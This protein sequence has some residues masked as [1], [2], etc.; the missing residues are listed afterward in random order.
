MP[1]PFD[2]LND[3]LSH[4]AEMLLHELLPGGKLVG[5]EYK[6]GSIMG[7]PGDS[8]SFNLD[9]CMGADF[10]TGEKFGDL[11]D[12]ASQVMRIGIGQAAR[13]LAQRI[14]FDIGD[15][16]TNFAPLPP[17]RNTIV[18]DAKP[19]PAIAYDLV[20]P[21]AGIHDPPFGSPSG[22]W[23][24]RDADGKLLFYIARYE[25]DDGGRKIYRPWSWDRIS[26]S[27]MAKMWPSPRPLYGLE[28]LRESTDKPV[29]I[30]EGEKAC[31]AARKI[32]GHIYNCISWPCGANAT[33]KVDWSPVFGKKVLIWP[34]ADDAG[35]QAQSSII[36][37]ISEQAVEI[38]VVSVDDAPEGWDLADGLNT[39][40]WTWNEM[41]EWAKKRIRII[42]A[43]KT[44][45]C[46]PPIVAEV[47][48]ARTGDVSPITIVDN[49]KV[50]ISIQAD[51]NEIAAMIPTDVAATWEELGISLNSRGVPFNNVETAH[52]I[53][54]GHGI[55]QNRLWYDEF[56]S[57]IFTDWTVSGERGR[58]HEITDDDVIQMHHLV[59]RHFQIHNLSIDSVHNAIRVYAAENKR[60]E[61]REW[62]ESLKWDG[63]SRIDLYLKNYLNAQ[64]S[65][66]TR[67]ASGNWWKGIA[68]RI[69][70]P[71][72]QLD[73]MIVL[74]GKQGCGK[75]SSMK[76]V[77]GDWHTEA[78]ASIM[79][80]D[81]FMSLQGK[82]IVEISEMDAFSKAE[83]T[84]VKRV[85]STS[86]DRFRAPYARLPQD[87][88][89]QCVFA[90]TTNVHRF[91]SDETG[92]RRFWP[93]EI[94]Q[95][96]VDA[97]MRDRNQLFAEAVARFKAGEAWHIMPVDETVEMQ[98]RHRH[99]DAWEAPIQ[100]WLAGRVDAEATLVDVARGALQIDT[101]RLD[102]NSQRRIA[103]ILTMN[104]WQQKSVTASDGKRP[105]RVW[106]KP[107][108]EVLATYNSCKTDKPEADQPEQDATL[109]DT[110]DTSH[111]HT[112][113]TWPAEF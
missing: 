51:P 9:K 69:F 103:A 71:G 13:A 104:G 98:E 15:S 89:R 111:I 12:L 22:L 60:N 10:A 48:P 5:R 1:I 68:A 21:P 47:V 16:S 43:K 78:S 25:P 32:C 108:S 4:H 81:F 19:T 55:F 106:V 82:L 73:S 66:Y 29:L 92:G 80:K 41:R 26:E 18:T 56:H 102:I 27:W 30:V 17:E 52:C 8:L 50:E 87:H 94:G 77:G 95:V 63:V 86:T 37:K 44:E 88:P 11:I 61:P 72:C 91:L 75:T 113:Q 67:C 101:G 58:V 28:I 59:V 74:V 62:L 109:T 23:T 33:E 24:Y 76:A 42:K 85:V 20:P 54:R 110:S 53:L 31:D 3:A 2:R 6:C 36:E 65:D 107:S 100:R 105:I 14:G 97:I 57:K 46:S 83:K 38:K 64:D 112:I 49:R 34:D 45:P 7:G 40:G 35:I 39:D 84:T 90:G 79:D 96:D 70:K 93:I 99:D